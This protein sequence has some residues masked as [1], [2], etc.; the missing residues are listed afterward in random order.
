MP[1]LLVK[2]ILVGVLHCSRSSYQAS[3][4][5]K[6]KEAKRQILWYM[7]VD[8]QNRP[9]YSCPNI[10]SYTKLQ[11]GQKIQTNKETHFVIYSVQ[12]PFSVKIT[13]L[14]DNCKI[15]RYY[16]YCLENRSWNTDKQYPSNFKCINNPDPINNYKISGNTGT[17]E[18]CE[19]N[20]SADYYTLY[21]S[22]GDNYYGK[23]CNY[24]IVYE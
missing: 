15:Y 10:Q 14:E 2:L 9:D 4:E 6:V 19:L 22:F 3:Y 1:I 18:K 21:I 13:L 17:F 23:P 16:G 12:K 20:F 7:V 24:E 8:F 5:E 11:I